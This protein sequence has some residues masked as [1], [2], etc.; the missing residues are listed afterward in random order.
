[1]GILGTILIDTIVDDGS[2]VNVLPEETWKK[3]GK[4][5]L[6][7][8]TSN[9][10]RVDQHGIKPLGTLMAQPITIETEPF[11]LDFIVIPLKK[12]GC[13]AIL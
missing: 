10:L 5:T 8:P 2:G 1:M 3:L 12:K 6:W 9:L 7:P 4:P 11:V 13:N